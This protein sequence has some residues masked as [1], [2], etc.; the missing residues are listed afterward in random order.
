MKSDGNNFNYFPENKLIKLANLVQFERMLMCF[1]RRIGVKD[2]IQAP[3]CLC[4]GSL[5]GTD[6]RGWTSRPL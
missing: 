3:P 6:Y 1:V 2:W 5:L 4:H